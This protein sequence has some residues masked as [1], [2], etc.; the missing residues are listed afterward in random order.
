MGTYYTCDDCL[1]YLLCFKCYRSRDMAH[2]EHTFTRYSDE[3]DTEFVD[4]EGSPLEYDGPD[5]G[6]EEQEEEQGNESDMQSRSP[7]A[8][9]ENDS[10]HTPDGSNME[11]VDGAE[12]YGADGYQGDEDIS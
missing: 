12:G 6:D 10:E 11:D 3:V 2:P 4:E 9:G 8:Y 7:S 1:D 5:Q